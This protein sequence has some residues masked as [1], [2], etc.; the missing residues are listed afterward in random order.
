MF[1]LLLAALLMLFAGAALLDE[2]LTSHLLVF[3]LF[4]GACAW[5][6]VTA[7]LLAC[8]DILVVSAAARAARKQL[9]KDVMKTVR[10]GKAP[11]D[12]SPGDAD[13]KS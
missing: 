13:G 6:T 8:F 10:D 5:L 1:R 3:I 7:V 4:W 9:E 11:E 2:F 12:D